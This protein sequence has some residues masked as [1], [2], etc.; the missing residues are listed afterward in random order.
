MEYIASSMHRAAGIMLELIAVYSEK[1]TKHTNR[2]TF[3]EQN[4]EY[5]N[6]KGG[7]L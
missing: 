4:S 2:P 5:Y 6:A 3:G 1:Y 7:G